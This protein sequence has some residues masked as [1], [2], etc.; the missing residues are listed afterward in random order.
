VAKPSL[1]FMWKSC[2][3]AA[4][5]ARISL[6]PAA[7]AAFHIPP[8]RNLYTQAG[9]LKIV[10]AEKCILDAISRFSTAKRMLYQFSV[11]NC[12]LQ[13]KQSARTSVVGVNRSRFCLLSTPCVAAIFVC[14]NACSP[15]RP[16]HIY[17]YARR[18]I[19]DKG[20]GVN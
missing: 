3:C 16:A 9:P 13:L 14:A 18:V 7:T 1:D 17:I 5:A 19:K 8:A 4:D 11:G 20:S 15:A 12:I 2:T 6:S 10:S